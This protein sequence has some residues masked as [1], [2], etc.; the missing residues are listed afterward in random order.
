MF[1]A[2]VFIA[3]FLI[4]FHVWGQPEI[5]FEKENFEMGKMEYGSDSYRYATF[6]N[7]G[8]SVL[9]IYNVLHSG[10]HLFV[11]F[12]RDSIYPGEKRKFKYSYYTRYPSVFRKTV[13]VQSNA[14]RKEVLLTFSGEVLEPKNKNKPQL[15]VTVVQTDTTQL[16]HSPVSITFDSIVKAEYHK[17]VLRRKLIITGFNH[18]GQLV[19]QIDIKTKRNSNLRNTFVETRYYSTGKVA[20]VISGT[21]DTQGFHKVE[22]TPTRRE[23]ELKQWNESGKIVY[24]A[25]WDVNGK[26]I[27]ERNY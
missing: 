4:P 8:D 18:D 6:I 12:P 15:P 17:K 19:Y 22:T 13:I 1:Y 3:M 5:S 10:G 21:G 16:N 11:E 20:Q 25:K 26:L 23:L 9:L 2:A 27:Y 7:T 24:E 14:N